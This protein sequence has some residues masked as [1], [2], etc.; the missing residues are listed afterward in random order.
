[1]KITRLVLTILATVA[2]TATLAAAETELRREAGE[3]TWKAPVPGKNQEA[4]STTATEEDGPEALAELFFSTEEGEQPYSAGGDR[5]EDD[6]CDGG[7]CIQC[8]CEK[9]GCACQGAESCKVMVAFSNHGGCER[10]KC[11]KS[12]EHCTCYFPNP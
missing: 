5:G 7:V 3:S 4:G 1:M 12:G 6:P 2:L 9:G 11:D 10:L 8:S